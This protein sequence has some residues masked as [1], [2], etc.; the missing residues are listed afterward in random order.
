MLRCCV[1]GAQL[2]FHQ[3]HPYVHLLCA[4]EELQLR[5]GRVLGVVWVKF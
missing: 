2:G 1:G 3:V 5:F 4:A